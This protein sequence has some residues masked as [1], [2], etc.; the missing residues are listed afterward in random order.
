MHSMSK[1]LYVSF[2]L[3]VEEGVGLHGSFSPLLTFTAS[4]CDDKPKGEGW[5]SLNL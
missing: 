3:N 5:S 4:C 1:D 2:V